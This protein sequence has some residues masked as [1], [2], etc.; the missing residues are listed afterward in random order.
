MARL[1]EISYNKLEARYLAIAGFL[2]L[3]VSLKHYKKISESAGVKLKQ[4]STF[5]FFG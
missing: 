5:S 4:L 3:V 1:N 2:I